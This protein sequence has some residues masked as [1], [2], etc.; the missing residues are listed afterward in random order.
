MPDAVV[1]VGGGGYADAAIGGA[2]M[3]FFPRILCEVGGDFD[4]ADFFRGSFF[5]F[6]RFFAYFL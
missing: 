2:G 3:V 1:E 4:G 6:H 5:S